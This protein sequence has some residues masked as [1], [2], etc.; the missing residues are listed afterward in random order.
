MHGGDLLELMYGLNYL[1]SL[2]LTFLG[3]HNNMK[4]ME[5]ICTEPMHILT[6]SA[7]YVAD[8]LWVSLL[9]FNFLILFSKLQKICNTVWGRFICGNAVYFPL[10]KICSIFVWCESTLRVSR[11]HQ[12]AL[13]VNT[14]SD[15]RQQSVKMY[16][17]LCCGTEGSDGNMYRTGF[18][19]SEVIHFVCI[20]MCK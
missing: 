10:W 14:E 17:L 12:L 3:S 4:P 5:K 16:T 9:T 8:M 18:I 1:T 11:C 7:I 13:T 2:F 6:C 19:C 15:E 20:Y